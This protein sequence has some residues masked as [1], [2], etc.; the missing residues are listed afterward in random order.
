[1]LPLAVAK[2]TIFETASGTA[3][4][5]G[6]LAGCNNLRCPH[7]IDRDRTD[8]A[9]GPGRPSRLGGCVSSTTND[10]QLFAR[11]SMMP[12]ATRP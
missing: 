4:Q 1:M 12:T 11:A 5:H 10:R 7:A 3:A 8:R 6:G 2:T 9:E